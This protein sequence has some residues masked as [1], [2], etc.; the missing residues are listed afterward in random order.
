MRE[1]RLTRRTAIA[2]L[3]GGVA[4]FAAAAFAPS[5]HGLW[6][7]RI[8]ASDGVIGLEFDSGLNSACRSRGQPFTP[9]EA[10]EG[11]RLADG[12]VLD[13]FIAASITD[14]VAAL[15]RAHATRC[16]GVADGCLRSKSSSCSATPIRA[17]R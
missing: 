15:R 3:M 1:P 14:R 17:L 4:T 2:G 7:R 5:A 8:S 11:V 6:S 10:S 12:R 13:R 9:L 16:T